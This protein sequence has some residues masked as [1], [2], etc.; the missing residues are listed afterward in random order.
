MD[1]APSHS[2]ESLLN[3]DDIFS[4]KFLASNVTSLIQPMDQGMIS[5]LKGFN[6]STILNMLLNQNDQVLEFR[7]KLTILDAVY[8]LSSTW[9]KVEPI[10]LIRSRKYILPTMISIVDDEEENENHVH[11][12]FAELKTLS[13]FSESLL[14]EH[15]EEWLLVDADA[16]GFETKNDCDIVAMANEEEDS[17]GSEE[18]DIA[19]EKI[20]FKTA[21]IHVDGLLTFMDQKGFEYCDKIA[22]CKIITDIN[23]MIQSAQKQSKITDFFDHNKNS[24]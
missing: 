7:K 24:T 6:R 17:S 14:I 20:D 21:K 16:H 10:T 8:A 23:Q 22:V 3:T 5:L 2:Q 1:N 13:C 9:N 11:K 18:E 12:M 19:Y 4:I 15:V